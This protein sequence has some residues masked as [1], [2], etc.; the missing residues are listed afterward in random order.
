[1]INGLSAGDFVTDR[2]RP[3]ERVAGPVEAFRGVGVQG[4]QRLTGAYSVA[5]LGVQ[6]DAGTG[7]DRVLL[8]GPA[9][10]QPP[11]RDPDGHGVQRDQHPV[12][13]R[14]DHLVFPGRRQLGVRVPALGDDHGTPGIHRPSR[15][16]RL[17]RIMII[18]P[19]GAE[20]LPGQRQRQ[21]DHIRRSAA[22]QHLH[23]FPDLQGISGG[24]AQRGGH[25]GEQRD[26]GDAGV[27]TKINH[28]P[29]ELAGRLLGLHEGAGSDFDVE[30][31]RAGA[32]GDLLAHD[33]R[34]D[35]RDRLDG[36][37]HVPQRVQ[38]P[39]GR[40]Q[41]RA[42]RADHRPDLLELVEHLGVGHRRPPAGDGLQLVQ[43]PAGVTQ[44]ASRQLW[45]GDTTGRDQRCE[46]QGD[47]VA[48]PSGGVLVG[49]RPRQ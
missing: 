34:R 7:L 5:R 13:V 10:T 29:G 8:A 2:V 47:L 25:V 11:R 42:G 6:L 14:G 18:V 16:Q 40:S 46:R 17:R 9:R 31:Q 3:G 30:H 21:F 20:H 48:D 15:A 36:A 26:R 19:G 39:V 23:G 1:M 33:R 44:A 35:Q 49:G 37:G 24:Q 41:S 28:G 27:L 43:R 4:Q 22:G 12:G 38:L 32:L 45:H